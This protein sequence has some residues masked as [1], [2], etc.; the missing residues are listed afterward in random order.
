LNGKEVGK[1][2]AVEFAGSEI[3]VTFEVSKKV[4]PL[5]TDRSVASLG[6]L[7]LLGEPILDITAARRPARRWPTGHTK[8][9]QKAAFGDLADS[10]SQ[11]L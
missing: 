1:V 10:A 3:D 8:A 9:G 5:I 4:R 11:G 6:S 2:T 7:S